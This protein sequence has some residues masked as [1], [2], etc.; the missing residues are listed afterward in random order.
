MRTYALL[1]LGF[2]C[3]MSGFGPPPVSGAGEDAAK[4]ELARLQGTWQLVAAETD[5]K[6][7]AEENVKQIRVVIRG[8]KHSVQFGEKVIAK[9]VPFTIDPTKRPRE[10]TDSLADGRTIRGI[11]ELDGD[12]LR[13]CVAAVGKDRPTRFAAE[14]GSGHTLRIFR[15]V[16]EK[17][18]PQ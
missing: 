17:T 16:T 6:K 13:S 5:G 4:E 12:T 9:E 1:V 8:G 11:Y 2:V 10:V 14:A 7:A 18:P 15:R 3:V